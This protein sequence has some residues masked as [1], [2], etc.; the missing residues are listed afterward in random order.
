MRRL[1]LVL[2]VL[3]APAVLFFASSV[4][5]ETEKEKLERLGREIEEYRAR[6][7]DLQGQATTLSNQIAQFDAK[8]SLTETQIEQTKSQIELLGGRISQLS[9]SLSVL[10]DAFNSRAVETYKV[11]RAG[12]PVFMVLT[13][14]NV[15]EVVSK[16]FYLKRIQSAD[17]DLLGRLASAQT[18][19]IDQRGELE[20]LEE[21]LAKQSQVLA[22]QKDA[23]ADLL[24]VTKNDE[25]QFQSLLAQAQAEFQAIQA[26]IAG[27]GVETEVGGVSAGER[28]A[29]VIQGA[30]CNSSGAHLHFIVSEQG[31]P[32]NPFNYLTQIDHENCSGGSCG[33]GGDPFNPSGSWQWPMSPKIRF[34][35]GYGH[36]WAVDNTFVGNIYQF[37]NG[38][39]VNSTSGPEVR[40]VQDGTLYQ[41]S[42]RG[43]SGCNLRYVRLDHKDSN[44]ET[45]YLHINY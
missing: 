29:S 39:D 26:I 37:H 30:S 19:Y 8:I 22:A 28:I 5:A 32:Q 35:Q 13:A 33:T 9:D 21:D 24:A 11:A 34:T 1:K 18:S 36:T 17:Q 7:T 31:N 20:V 25:K 2:L 10:S 14:N 45:F 41:G 3:V 6:I 44:L 12:D 16:Q 38:L 23:K 43:S 27:R 4:S 42:F 40:A 15:S